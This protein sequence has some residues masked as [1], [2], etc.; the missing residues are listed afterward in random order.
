MNSYDDPII[1]EDWLAEAHPEVFK[2]YQA[3]RDIERSIENAY[4]PDDLEAHRALHEEF[5]E[6]YKIWKGKKVK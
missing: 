5:L 6:A 3:V 1:L 4:S 2:Q